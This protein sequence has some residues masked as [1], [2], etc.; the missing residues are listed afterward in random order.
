[1]HVV[2]T[3]GHVDSGKST[4]V[5][6]LTGMEP[7]RWEE[8]RRR[9]LTIDLGYAWTRLPSGQDVAFVDVPGHERFLG[10]MLAG[11]GPAPVVCFVVAADEGWQAQSSDHRDAVAALGIEHGVVVLSRADRASRE[12][13]GEVL[14]RTRAE[15]AGTGLN[16]APA[17][18]VSAVD[19][20]GLAD[21]RAALDGVLA[22]VPSPT[23]SG[24][25]RLWVDR[26]FTITGSGTIVTGTLA[27][28]TIAQ[29]DRLQMLGHLDSRSVVVRGLQ[30]CDT[31]YPAVGP[32]SRVALNL[33]DISAT[34]IRRGDALVTPDAWP[35]TGVIGIR[36]TTG[37]PYTEAPE[38]LM[39]HV[40]T[41]S[42]PAR[43][44]AFDADNARLVL[45]RHLPLV[46]GDRLVLR[47]PGSRLVLGGARILDGDPPA[48]RRRG[49]GAHWAER[50]AGM[51]S[52]GDVLG[53]VAARG[54]VKEEHLRRL[55]L[56]SGHDG[57]IPAGV[58][59]LGEWWVHDPVLEAWQQKLNRAVRALQERDY[60]APGLSMGAARDLLELP[61][62][63]LL[64][65]VIRGAGLEQ[66]GGHVRLPGSQGDL[67]A[68]EPAVA[69]L[70]RR[71][72]A[73][74]FQA[75]ESDQLAALG[76]GARELAAAERAGR[77]LRLRD[78][79]VL[80]PSAPAF[81][82]RA[83]ARLEQPFTTSEARQALDTTRRVAVPL[84][85]HLD[86]RGW[87]R[88]LDAGHRTVVR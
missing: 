43:L 33:R 21:L 7:D 44:R 37:V 18:T 80:L 53:E 58:R 54:A 86:A 30:S 1:M 17:V 8:E 79:V 24:R 48:L 35:T 81:A 84:L 27:A 57:E 82:M 40:G 55:G 13:I 26:S 38:Q 9:G 11:I 15:L 39:V 46:L 4:L 65:H 10:N 5:R 56:L 36:R 31:S 70:E 16:D 19:G 71:L 45:D 64:A 2:A 87:T 74:A 20:T 29:G 60:L 67:G 73:H 85:E 42:V 66:D 50:L 23:T 68:V 83:L 32:V 72:A 77:V 41:A 51:D 59:A 61:D 75:P 69:E 63:R 52:A 88:R 34:D 47:D 78:G 62:E 3:A 22:G 14:A 76:L 6:A 28:G 49:D 12:R 25:V